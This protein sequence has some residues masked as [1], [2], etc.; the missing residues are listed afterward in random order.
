VSNSLLNIINDIFPVLNLENL[1]SDAMASST[2]G[3]SCTDLAED[4]VCDDVPSCCVEETIVSYF[5]RLGEN[6]RSKVT[7]VTIQS[8]FDSVYLSC[9]PLL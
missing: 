4:G 1:E 9:V 8:D 6:F 5:Y 7:N 2:M 3:L